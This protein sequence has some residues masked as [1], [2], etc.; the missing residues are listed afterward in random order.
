MRSAEIA[1]YATAYRNDIYRMTDCLKASLERV[2]APMQRGSYL[3][4]GTGRGESLNLATG[5][6]FGPVRGT[7]VV[8]YLLSDRVEYAEVHDLPFK[9]GQFD[10][11]SCLDVLEHLDPPDTVDALHEIRRVAKRAVVVSA[12]DYSAVWAGVELHVNAKPYDEWR[13]LV[14]EHI[15]HPVLEMSTGQSQL[16]VVSCGA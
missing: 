7:E 8:E 1:K 11:V 12:A 5:M 3:D 16:W 15:G 10:V 14:T 4:I 13:R 6:G 2:L 9:T